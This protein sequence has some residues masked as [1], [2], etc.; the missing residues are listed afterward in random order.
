MT[1]PQAD[2]VTVVVLAGGESRRFGSDKLSAPLGG[3]T[4]FDHVVSGLP[5]GWPVVAVGAAR[6]VGREVA[7][8]REDPPGGGPLAAVEAGLAAVRTGI[9]VVVAG[10][11]P[12]AG[13]VVGTLV[14]ALHGSDPEVAA[15]VATDEDGVPNP[16][17]AAYRSDAVREG[18][19]RP[20]HGR[21][22]RSLLQLPHVEV[23][24]TGRAVRDVDTPADLEVL[25]GPPEDR[26]SAR[27]QPG[28]GAPGRA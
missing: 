23:R 13:G 18:L 5:P 8:T 15:A 6:K 10:D 28:F 2:D 20:T 7:W 3:A 21:P 22:A 26:A 19:P 12:F 11:M 14:E 1:T 9:L 24:L 4:V 16:L 17:L 25:G 27:G